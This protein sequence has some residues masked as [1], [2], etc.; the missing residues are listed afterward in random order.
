MT[1][2]DI[3][4][5]ID[6][7]KKEEASSAGAVRLPCQPFAGLQIRADKYIPE[8]K[9]VHR[10]ERKWAHRCM[11]KRYQ[12]F[13]IKTTP[14]ILRTANGLFAHPNTVELLKNLAIAL[15]ARGGL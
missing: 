12:R 3:A 7:I 5:M 4:A 10:Q 8:T 9:E 6:A 15:P 1:F 11:W 14:L 13:T 2:K